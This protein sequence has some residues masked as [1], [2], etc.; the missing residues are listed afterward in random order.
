M[1]FYIENEC[2]VTFP[3][4]VDEQI[5]KVITQ[6]LNKEECPYE[7]EVNITITSKELIR[8]YNK[9]YRNIDKETD[10]LSFPAVDYPQ[11]G[12]FSIAENA[13][14]TYFN[15]DTGELMLGDIIICSDRVFS[16]AQEYGHSILRE[17]SFLIA[18]SMLHL[19]GYDHMNTEEETEMFAKQNLVLESLGITREKE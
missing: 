13:V 15:P 12:D 11:P 4:S 18:H 19:L 9:E 5:K 2:D 17:F 6:V 10:V 3:F 1:T 7:C 14:N 8:K 16:Q